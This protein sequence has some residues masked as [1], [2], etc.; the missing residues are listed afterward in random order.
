MKEFVVKFN[1][2][3][4]EYLTALRLVAGAVASISEVDLDTAE[5]FKVC[6]TESVLI[7]KNCGFEEAKV[8]FKADEGVRCTAEGLG[9]QPKEGENELSLA[10]ISALM[11]NCDIERTGDIIKRVCLKIC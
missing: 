4:D 7:L 10:L 6:V 11:E 5:D 9:G 1:L 2:K 3:D 8:T